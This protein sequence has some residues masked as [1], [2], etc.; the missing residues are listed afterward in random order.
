MI[1]YVGGK[2]QGLEEAVKHRFPDNA[3]ILPALEEEIR[4]DLEARPISLEEVPRRAEEW[5]KNVLSMEQK[6]LLVVVCREVGCGVIPMEK[7]EE[8]YRELVG[9]LQVL[10]A[11][12]AS[13]VWRVWCG[14]PERIR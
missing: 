10:L 7:K 13:E 8:I 2:A 5:K 1:L 12:E 6:K 11:A 14:I 3:L 4:R 9:R